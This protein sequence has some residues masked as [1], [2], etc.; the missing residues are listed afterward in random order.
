[1][2]NENGPVS[3]EL[4]FRFIPRPSS[5]PRA[6][7]PDSFS[8]YYIQLRMMVSLPNALRVA[9]R[10]N[11]PRTMGTAAFST[12]ASRAMASPAAEQPNMKKFKIYRWVRMGHAWPELTK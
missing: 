12:S 6:R 9:V 1:M 10:A 11:I 8:I 4:R 5:K 7:F 3:N 2:A